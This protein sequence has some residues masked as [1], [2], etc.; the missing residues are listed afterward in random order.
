MLYGSVAL[1]IA[2]VFLL[3]YF[4]ELDFIVLI[5]IFCSLTI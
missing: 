5:S 3:N 2:V 4:P 1:S